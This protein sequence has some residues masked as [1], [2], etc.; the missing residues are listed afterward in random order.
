LRHSH[1]RTRRVN[2][3]TSHCEVAG[4]RGP[5]LLLSLES[6]PGAVGSSL[7]Q[8]SLAAVPTGDCCK[9]LNQLCCKLPFPAAVRHLIKP[10]RP[11][12]PPAQLTHPAP[13]QSHR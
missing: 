1:I 9:C 2:Y 6:L 11:P 12:P 3:L 5:S 7:Q 13:V 8:K 4:T 10:W